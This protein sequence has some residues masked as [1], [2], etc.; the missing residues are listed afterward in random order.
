MA[1]VQQPMRERV[2]GALAACAPGEDTVRLEAE[3]FEGAASVIE[4]ARRF[5]ALYCALRV[6]SP[7]LAARMSDIV[8][9]AAR[10]EAASREQPALEEEAEEETT[11]HATVT[12]RCGS[13]LVKDRTVQA[14]CA[15]EAPDVFY[16]CRSCGRSWRG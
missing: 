12:C 7:Q 5:T 16:A 15:D 9:S 10:A 2:R 8:E 4:Y 6:H 11:G 14:R 1:A 3:I 13:S